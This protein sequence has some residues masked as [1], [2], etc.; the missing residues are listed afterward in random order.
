MIIQTLSVNKDIIKV[1]NKISNRSLQNM[2]HQTNK[3]TWC[4]SYPQRALLTTHINYVLFLMLLSIHCHISYEFDGTHFS[5]YFL[6]G[7]WNHAIHLACHINE[8]WDVD[9]KP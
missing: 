5:N 2:I 1:N 9:T 4:I 8:V 7:D 3:R 6:K